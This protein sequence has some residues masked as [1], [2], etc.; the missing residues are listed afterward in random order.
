MRSNQYHF[1]PRIPGTTPIK[2]L[3]FVMLFFTVATSDAFAQRIVNVE[4]GFNTLNEAIN[5]DTTETGARVDTNTVYVLERDGLYLLN[6]AIQNRF[7]LTIVAADGEGARPIVQPGVGD[8]GVSDR[9][10]RPRSDL[11][12][13]GLYVTNE[14]ELG[15]LNT[16]II[17]ISGDDVRITIDDCHLDKDAQSAFRFDN[18][19][20]KVYLTNSIVSNI[21][22]SSSMN[23][24][25]GFDTRGNDI[26]SLVV[27]NT[28]FYNLTSRVVRDDGGG[29]IKYHRFNHNTVV[30]V[31]QFVSSPNE[32]LD[33]EFTN[34]LIINGGYLGQT[35]STNADRQMIQID[36]LSVD[37]LGN[38]IRDG[39]QTIRIS[40]NNFY[41]DSTIMEAYGDSVRTIPTFNGT[42]QAYIDEG[43]FGDTMTEEGVMFTNAPAVPLN[44]FTARWTVGSE[45]PDDDS[46][47]DFDN[48]G[49]PY[50]FS[51][52]TTFDSYTG[53]R[54]E[55]PLGSLDWFGLDIMPVSI[56]AGSEA[57]PDGFLLS[58][59]Y[60]NP[61]NPV[62]TVAFDL[63]AAA[64]VSI[65]VFDL[66]GREVLLVP[67]QPMTKGSARTIQ[68][69][70]GELASGIYLYQVRAEIG[71]RMHVATGKMALLK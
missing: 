48:A 63:P 29:F 67:A 52:A 4:P 17:R 25:R 68:V 70:A 58:G 64:N 32:V 10:F 54:A 28:T 56:E 24:G 11:T 46:I 38:P 27:E 26:D 43:G 12:L 16:R 7:P 8:G 1:I 57:Q 31:G 30:N 69:D 21:G 53:S 62:T 19:G 60:P 66:L 23:N 13:R 33:M 47:P 5:A 40:N 2:A 15:G 51:Y 22:R 49:A 41:I 6:G 3:A 39:E 55:Q 44:V 35:D 71:N 59:N 42:A 65:S 14:D 37:S 45:N 34:N 20:I 9:P 61:F 50:D 18:N 36:S